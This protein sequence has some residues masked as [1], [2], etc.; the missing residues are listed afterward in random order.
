MG[1]AAE[2][3]AER[4]QLHAFRGTAVQQPAPR[5]VSPHQKSSPSPAAATGRT[6]DLSNFEGGLV[7]LQQGW[8]ALGVGRRPSTPRHPGMNGLDRFNGGCP[9]SHQDVKLVILGQGWV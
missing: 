9:C 8:L 1:H 6:A 5:F 2:R 3:P 7:Q 4:C